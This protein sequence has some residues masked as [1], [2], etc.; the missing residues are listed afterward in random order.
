MTREKDWWEVWCEHGRA[1][2]RASSPEAARRQIRRKHPELGHAGTFLNKSA[3]YG[4]FLIV[5]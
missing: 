2:V 5:S 4:V 1:L 3:G